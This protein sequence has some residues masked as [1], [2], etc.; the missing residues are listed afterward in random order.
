MFDQVVLVITK[1]AQSNGFAILK[2]EL[3]THPDIPGLTD[4]IKHVIEY[5]IEQEYVNNSID[6]A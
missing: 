1:L 3:V 2:W 6:Y 5:D 4:C